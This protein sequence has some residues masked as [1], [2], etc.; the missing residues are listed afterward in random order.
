MGI[1][2]SFCMYLSVQEHEEANSVLMRFGACGIIQIISHILS[3]CTLCA[4]YTV[5]WCWIELFYIFFCL[6]VLT[7]ICIS[8][9][10]C[11]M[12]RRRARFGLL[13]VH[14]EHG[15]RVLSSAFPRLVFECFKLFWMFKLTRL[16]KNMQ[17]IS[18]CDDGS[19]GLSTV[20]SI[21]L[22]RPRPVSWNRRGSPSQ[23][24]APIIITTFHPTSYGP[25]AVRK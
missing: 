16:K 2:T 13:C 22:G 19:R 9:F 24:W 20:Q 4:Q 11:R 6:R 7:A 25:G 23:S 17:M 1:C 8:S 12:T 14:T 3:G 5:H 10:R 21:F 15:A 18:Y